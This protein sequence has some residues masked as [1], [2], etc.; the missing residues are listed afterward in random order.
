MT[1]FKQSRNLSITQL[2][3]DKIK[4]KTIKIFLTNQKQTI[5]YS[6]YNSVKYFKI[7]KEWKNDNIKTP[8]I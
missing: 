8:T 4:K 2:D 6:R 7:I 3:K 5:F 1:L